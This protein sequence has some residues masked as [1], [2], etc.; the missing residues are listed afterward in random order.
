MSEE[1][2][3][4]KEIER[5]KCELSL[6]GV[7]ILSDE[8]S[9]EIVADVFYSFVDI[10]KL[11]KVSL[12][13]IYDKIDDKLKDNSFK[14]E[15]EL[16]ELTWEEF[17]DHLYEFIP[18]DDVPLYLIVSGADVE[19]YSVVCKGTITEIYKLLFDGVPLG[20]GGDFTIVPTSYDWLVYYHDTDEKL[21]YVS[22][23]A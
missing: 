17:L 9:K 4:K 5:L 12:N 23:S 6:D 1:E 21:C 22:E 10:S 18:T 3:V 15:V 19:E 7:T 14:K 2:L 11:S 20:N 13:K 16:G 8:N